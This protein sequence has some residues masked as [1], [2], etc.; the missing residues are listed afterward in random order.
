MGTWNP[1]RAVVGV[2]VFGSLLFPGLPGVVRAQ[3]ATPSPSVPAPRPPAWVRA[4]QDTLRTGRPTLLVVTSRAHPAS[5][6]LWQALSNDPQAQSVRQAFQVVELSAEANPQRI[7]SLQVTSFPTL[8]V[9]G[10]GANGLTMLGVEAGSM[11]LPFALGWLSGLKTTAS[12]ASGSRGDIRPP[13]AGGRDANLARAGYHDH[14]PSAQQ[15]SPQYYPPPPAPPAPPPAPAQPMV[16]VA[17]V[18]PIYSAPAPQPVVVSAPSPPVV[19]Q[20]SA[21]TIVVGPTPQPNIVF[22]QAPAPTVTYAMAP[23]APAPAAPAPTNLFTQPAPA[24]APA[25]SAPAPSAAAPLAYAPV[26][27][28]PQVAMAPA[29]PA[30]Q[31][32]QSPLLAAAILTNPRLW[33]RILGAIGEHLAQKKQPR[34]QMAPAPT[35]AQ[36]PVAPAGYAPAPAP[37]GAA[38]LAYAPMA[39][40]VQPMMLALPTAPAP[41]Y[42]PVAPVYAPAAAPTYPPAY[43][44]PPPSAPSPQSGYYPAPPKSGHFHP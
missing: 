41:A 17:P 28:A 5:G 40:A 22:A 25:P 39:A 15:P 4:I 11:D 38:P 2:S 13:L 18:A 42:V 37:S 19:F 20:P 34:I 3:L 26:A 10:R 31:V 8:I 33:E 29:A 27:Y 32:G 1:S 16:P 12:T 14:Y 7:Q 30:P 9:Y 21:P 23:S 6:Q 35:V 36:A 44:A 24:P 43:Q